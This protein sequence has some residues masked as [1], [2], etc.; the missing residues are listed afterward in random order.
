M[1]GTTVAVLTLRKL[2]DPI[3][4]RRDNSLL[5]CFKVLYPH[6][7]F[8]FSV[9][10]LRELFLQVHLNSELSPKITNCFYTFG[11]SR[12]NSVT[13]VTRLRVWTVLELWFDSRPVAGVLS[14]LQ[15]DQTSSGT[16]PSPPSFGFLIL[17]HRGKSDRGV[18]L[19]PH[20]I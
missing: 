2:H 19:F 20:P 11:D 13:I 6:P 16:H 7:S 18:K 5:V 14:L 12:V 10:I 1:A 9:Y 17:F 15:N 8:P 4:I 3:F